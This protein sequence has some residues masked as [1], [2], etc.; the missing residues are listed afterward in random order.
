M[1]FARMRCRYIGVLFI[2][3]RTWF[4]SDSL[5]RGSTVGKIFFWPSQNCFSTELR[6]IPENMSCTTLF[7]AF[8][9]NK[10]CQR[11]SINEDF[12][13]KL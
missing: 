5:Y 13:E 11:F 1:A 10:V 3:P 6:Q 9:S 4:C 12:A 8:I 2:I 7:I